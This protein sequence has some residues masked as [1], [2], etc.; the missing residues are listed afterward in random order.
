MINRLSRVQETERA[1]LGLI[2]EIENPDGR[3]P[4]ETEIAERFGVSRVTVRDALS[5]LAGQ[6]LIV[7]KQGLG[8][9]VNRTISDVPARLDTLLEISQLIESSG[10]KPEITLIDH[11]TGP[12]TPEIAEKLGMPPDGKALT[13]HKVFSA[14]QKPAAYVVNVIPL[15]FIPSDTLDA[16]IQQIDPSI[17][18]YGVLKQWFKQEVV[19]QIADIGVHKADENLAHHLAYPPDDP[20]LYI[21]EVGFNEQN[22]PVLLCQEYYRTGM[23][24]F[25]LV[26][27]PA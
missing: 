13:V 8:T 11:Y 19:Y 1:L 16:V 9:F 3:L 23:I 6:G 14:D 15:H 24:Q 5:S 27:R 4:A 17:Q 10:H 22:Q 26:R 20:V 21:E 12:T 25:R 2:E 18:I 7:R